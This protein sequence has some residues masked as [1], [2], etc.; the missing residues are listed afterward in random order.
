MGTDF[1]FPPPESR[2]RRSSF[3]PWFSFPDCCGGLRNLGN[4]PSSWRT[5]FSSSAQKVPL[6]CAILPCIE[7][8]D[9]YGRLSEV[10]LLLDFFSM[11]PARV[12]TVFF[13][14]NSTSPHL[15]LQACSSPDP[16]TLEDAVSFSFGSA[17]LLLRRPSQRTVDKE[18]LIA[19]AWFIIQYRT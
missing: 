5:L 13:W 7:R 18:Q 8:G 12:K 19:I 1:P 4:A 17:L 3:S 14:V 11:N 16:V 9:F 15:W 6:F 2:R 10:N